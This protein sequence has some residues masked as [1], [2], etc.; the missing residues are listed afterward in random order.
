VDALDVAAERRRLV[1]QQMRK[2][3]AA[4]TLQRVVDRHLRVEHNGFSRD[5]RRWLIATRRQ[6]VAALGFAARVDPQRRGFEQFESEIVECR[7]VAVLELQ[8]DL[9]DRLAA[10]ALR[11]PD[12]AAVNRGL[13]PRPGFGL[14]LDRHAVELG[15]EQRAQLPGD[16]P[17]NARAA[18][19][20]PRIRLVVED[21]ILPFAAR[22]QILPV[23]ILGF[24]GL[25]EP[26][27][28]LAHPQDRPGSSQRL[29]RRIEIGRHKGPR[30]RDRT[31]RQRRQGSRQISQ[32]SRI[33]GEL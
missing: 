32:I 7:R 16:P 20:R 26:P 12:H 30:D 24:Q 8:L 18:L 1:A 15:D 2:A 28:L 9:A 25:Y 3:G 14:D 13:D 31:R 29:I 17:R 10:A 4:D 5:R 27:V 23:R 19:A 22:Q 11:S 21:R 6:P 33:G